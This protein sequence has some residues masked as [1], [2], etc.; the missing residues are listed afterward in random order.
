MAHR[1]THVHTSE[2][3]RIEAARMAAEACECVALAYSGRVP[4]EHINA[5]WHAARAFTRHANRLYRRAL[6]RDE[7]YQHWLDT[8]DNMGGERVHE[9]Q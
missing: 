9:S 2:E 8:L 6:A 1:I 4:E 3:D 7:E 5:V